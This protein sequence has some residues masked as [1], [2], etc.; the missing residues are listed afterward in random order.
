[1][2]EED[3]EHRIRVRA[4]FHH[5]AGTGGGNAQ[6]D[7]HLA[8]LEER[9]VDDPRQALTT[10]IQE[11]K[12]AY[13]RLLWS[14]AI[15]TPREYLEGS[16]LFGAGPLNY[17]FLRP[18]VDVAECIGRMP[19]GAAVLFYQ[20]TRQPHMAP[21]HSA[22][23]RLR[24]WWIESSRLVFAESP[25]TT[26]SSLAG[27]IARLRTAISACS[28][29]VH[30]D[31]HPTAGTAD[32]DQ[33][34]EDA[35]DSL[36]QLL[37]PGPVGAAVATTQHLLVVP[38][39]GIGTVPFAILR[40]TP[41]SRPL[42]ETTDLTILPSL[43][44]LAQWRRAPADFGSPLV[45]GDPELTGDLSSLPPL[46]GA[47]AEAR[48]VGAL[49]SVPA[50]LGSDATLSAVRE[51][52][53]AAELIYIASHAA[54]DEGDPLLGSYIALADGRWT[55]QEIQ[56]QELKASLVVLSACQTGLGRV[57]DAG[58]VGLARAFTLAGAHRVVIS[59]WSVD[60]ATT[61]P[62]MTSFIE[63][64]RSTTAHTALRLAMCEARAES[65]D[66]AVWAS[67][68]VFGMPDAGPRAARELEFARPAA[69]NVQ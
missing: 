6:A 24:C 37:F 66:P 58:M 14:R 47:R 36:A 46:P 64:L 7:W 29:L 57:H 56:E 50:L 53:S 32:A 25:I 31:V 51:R 69:A 59:L 60:D 54:A 22:P 49:V 27:V 67:F 41:H 33:S 4:Y 8:E 45:V 2:G 9:T 42:V 63:K 19:S 20:V 65:R 28:A 43:L 40:P 1:M 5:I 17:T 12:D 61:V 3:I 23:C 11:Y 38:I 62:L 39:L 68:A 35:G 13:H 16:W 48:A 44:D 18:S 55:A 10:A 26:V 52:A 21:A 30:R 34:L 15:S